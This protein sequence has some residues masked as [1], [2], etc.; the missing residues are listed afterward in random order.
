LK[1]LDA[2]VQTI[3]HVFRFPGTLA[4]YE[5]AARAV[6]ELLDSWSL[7][8]ATCYK[9]ELAFEELG[10][11]IVLH[12]APKEDVAV[13]ISRDEQEVALTFEHDGIEFDPRGH[14]APVAPAS[15][16]DAQI[17][18]LGLVLVRDL[19]ARLDYERTP[20]RR[21]RLTV[22]IAIG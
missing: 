6:R 20:D 14:P 10:T 19:A 4:G 12:D 17:G 22:A 8:R 5:T 2:L 15:I 7:D 18:G 16:E 3:R 13:T 1:D 9:L 11:N 21:N